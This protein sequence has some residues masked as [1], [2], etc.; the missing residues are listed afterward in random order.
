MNS[1]N[2]PWAISDKYRARYG[3]VWS[4]LDF[5][6]ADKISQDVFK[7]EPMSTYIGDLCIFNQKIKMTYKDLLNYSKFTQISCHESYTTGT[8][9]DSYDVRIKSNTFTLQRHELRKLSETLNE[10]A[11]SALKAYELG[12]YL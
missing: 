4:N 12:L 5:V 2:H 6:F 11:S 8:K 7:S 9:H 10:A 3:E 1:I